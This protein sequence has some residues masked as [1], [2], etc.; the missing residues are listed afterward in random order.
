MKEYKFKRIKLSGLPGF[1]AKPQENYTEVINEYGKDE[2]ELLQIFAPPFSF[3][4]GSKYI[5]LIFQREK[6]KV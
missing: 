3:Y 1:Y 2:W 6:R 5:E 4:G